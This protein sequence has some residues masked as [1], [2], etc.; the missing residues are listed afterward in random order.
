GLTMFENDDVD[1]FQEE[2]NPN[3]KNQYKTVNG[4][5]DYKIRRKT[6]KVKDSSDV[7]LEVKETQHGPVMNGF[8][9]GIKGAKPVSMSWIY[10]QQNNQMLEAVYAL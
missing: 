1:M 2:E 8:L 4:F 10:I 7:V 3:N 9:D 6:I 5:Q